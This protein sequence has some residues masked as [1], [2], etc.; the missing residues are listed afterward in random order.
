MSLSFPSAS[1]G[2]HSGR[3]ERHPGATA[4]QSAVS[5]HDAPIASTSSGTGL[6]PRRSLPGPPRRAQNG[7]GRKRGKGRGRQMMRASSS[8]PSQ[9][10]EDLTGAPPW[11]T[12]KIFYALNSPRLAP[13]HGPQQQQAA[14]SHAQSSSGLSPNFL[15]VLDPAL[16]PSPESA[17]Q[18]PAHPH[19]TSK[20]APSQYACMARL[21]TPVWVQTIGTGRRETSEAGR[22]APQF[23]RVTLKTC[24]SAICISRCVLAGLPRSCSGLD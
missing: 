1:N 19:T 5:A 24:L 6:E 11:R 15:A 7:A 21:S 4:P 16:A 2:D 12:V 17:A 14:P 22:T 18:T 8:L 10:T 20:P 3:E 23:G 9:W 13:S